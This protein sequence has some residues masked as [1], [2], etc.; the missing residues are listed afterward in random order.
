MG[1]TTTTEDEERGRQLLSAV[2]RLIADPADIERSVEQ[3]RE[4]LGED[5]GRDAIAKA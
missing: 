5:A 4:K 2:E 3:L 1:E